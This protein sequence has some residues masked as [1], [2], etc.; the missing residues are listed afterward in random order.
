MRNHSKDLLRGV[1]I[2]GWVLLLCGSLALPTEAAAP[3][4]ESRKAEVVVATANVRSAAST[5]ASIVFRLPRGAVARLLETEGSW[6]LIE[7]AS[8]RRG[9]VFESVVQ[10]GPEPAAPVVEAPA[11]PSPN[12]MNVA[13]DHKPVSCIVAEQYPKLDACLSPEDSVGRAYVHFRALGTE[14]VLLER[15]LAAS[16]QNRTRAARLLGIGRR[17]LRSTLKR[18]GLAP[19]A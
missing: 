13:I 10:L 16:G 2:R 14:R 12:E 6:Y 15:A 8:G 3:T 18:H 9:Y 7:D 1:T 4:A 5:T 11:P 17:T 19:G